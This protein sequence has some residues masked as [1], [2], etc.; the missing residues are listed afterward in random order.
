[1][2]NSMKFLKN[3]NTEL[4]YDLVTPILGYLPK[5]TE[6]RNFNTKV[7]SSIIQN[8]QP[9]K[10]P[11]CPSRDEWINKMQVYTKP[12]DIIQP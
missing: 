9:W 7:H 1:M 5:G 4:P 3:L 12:E 8:R 2:E 10:Q 6:S 11:K